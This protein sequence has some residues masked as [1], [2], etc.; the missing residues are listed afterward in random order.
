MTKNG[1]GGKLFPPK[2]VPGFGKR[3]GTICTSSKPWKQ[4]RGIFP[5]QGP[6]MINLSPKDFSE[7]RSKNRVR[8]PANYISWFESELIVIGRK[9]V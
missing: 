5:S 3:G 2:N 8:N 6:L 4:G 9:K 1:G 7:R